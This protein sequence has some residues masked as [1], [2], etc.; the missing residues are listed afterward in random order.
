MIKAQGQTRVSRGR[1]GKM[2]LSA[3]LAVLLFIQSSSAFKLVCYFTNWAQYRPEVGRFLPENVDPHLCTHLIYAFANMHNNK[4]TTFEWNDETLYQRF[5]GLKKMNP[6]LK[7]L[8]AIG[9]WNFGTRKFTQMVSSA[10][11]RQMFMS[12]VVRFLRK[13]GFDGLDLDWEYPGSRESPPQDKTLFTALVQDLMKSFQQEAEQTGQQRLL[14]SA[15]VAAGKD[16][17][18]AGYE[19][20]KISQVLDFINVMTY[21]LHGAWESVTGHVSP[22]Y[23]GMKDTGPARY[24]NVDYAMSHWKAKGAPAE[25]LIMGIPTYGRS[26][27]LA[28]SDS[29][30]GA[31]AAG[32]A[33]PGQFTREAGFWAYYEICT[34]L[35]DAS[36]T[37][38]EEQKVPFSVKRN[39]WVGYENI[40]SIK[41]KV[42]YLKKNGFG[43]AMVWAIDLD[44]F[45]GSACNQGK[46]P[47]IGTLKTQL[48]LGDITVD[49]IDPTPS[50]STHHVK[51][52]SH[53]FQNNFC[54]DRAD[55]IFADPAD[56]SKY[57]MC[58]H[59][60]T[61]SFSCPKELVFNDTCKC[62]NW[63]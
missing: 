57:Y 10:A 54:L 16:V 29:A 4:I 27:I 24:F 61:F 44:D 14:L 3:A 30:V 32:P 38:I 46:Y 58:S 51:T 34:F 21:D 25:K 9:G 40:E 2:R 6:H 36:T 47:L 56:P 55:G 52:S 1:M 26:F 33:L 23:K 41:L 53:S 8:L 63:S 37:W 59:A 28:S 13:H 17:I 7:T 42:Q 15:A 35:R 39:Q 18:D 50:P 19:I 43:G 5:N 12:S 48:A 45:T 31:A 60:M 62:C 20:A 11:T 49:N 22:L